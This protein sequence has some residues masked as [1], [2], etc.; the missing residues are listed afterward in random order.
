MDRPPL[1]RMLLSKGADVNARTTDGET[2]L[3]LAFRERNDVS[4]EVVRELVEHGADV[5]AENNL[6]VSVLWFAVGHM[7]HRPEV[8]EYLL[9]HGANPNA[10]GVL[11]AAVDSDRQRAVVQA[12]LAKGADP[13]V[14]DEKGRTALSL[15]AWRA[16]DTAKMLLAA[17]AGPC[18]RRDREGLLVSAAKVGA[19][20][21]VEALLD[22]HVDVNA[23]SDH[24]QSAL[25]AAAEEG[26][27]DTVRL[28]LARGAAVNAR[29]PQGPTALMAAIQAGHLAIVQALVAKHAD[30]HTKATAS[31]RLS[32][33]VP[34]LTWAEMNHHDDI[35]AFL[36]KQGA[37]REPGR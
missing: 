12:L 15:A 28:L 36:K 21:A 2:A 13:N 9:S 10:H 23:M 26:H 27:E 20:R 32:L 8:V 33:T 17:G 3:M 4:T 25:M 6:G 16:Y 7:G 11:V 34:P 35:A 14:K 29:L 5:S 30:V 37:H 24:G 19:T 1:V 31:F 18:E 22:E